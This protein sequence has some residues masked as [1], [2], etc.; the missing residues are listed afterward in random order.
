MLS[1]HDDYGWIP[2]GGDQWNGIS[3]RLVQA[4]ALGKPIITGEAGIMGSTGASGCDSLQNRGRYMSAKI[5]AQFAA[6]V[7]A[8]LVWNWVLD[9]L[10][11]CNYNTGPSDS[12]LL[13]AAA[14]AAN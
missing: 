5:S 14:S 7:S 3:E 1:V 12:S 10:G 2:L 8:F 13:A 6:G 11:P 4:K 9:P